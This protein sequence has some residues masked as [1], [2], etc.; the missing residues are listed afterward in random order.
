VLGPLSTQRRTQ[1][2]QPGCNCVGSPA[3]RSG[4]PDR[5]TSFRFCH[6]SSR[7]YL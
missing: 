3:N 4:L 6:G 7:R 5:R 2:R 1:T